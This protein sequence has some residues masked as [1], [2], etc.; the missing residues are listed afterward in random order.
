MQSAVWPVYSMKYNHHLLV[1]IANFGHI[2]SKGC[3]RGC[4]ETRCWTRT[5]LVSFHPL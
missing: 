3:G 4:T 1:N 5:G 2:G